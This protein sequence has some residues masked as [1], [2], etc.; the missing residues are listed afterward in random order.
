MLILAASGILLRLMERADPQHGTIRAAVRVLIAR[1]DELV[2][3]TQE[4]YRNALQRPPC[5]VRWIRRISLLHLWR[6]GWD[7]QAMPGFG[8]PTCSE[9]A[10]LE[11]NSAGEPGLVRRRNGSP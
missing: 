2:T 9:I 7:I 1:G 11:L 6:T 10:C 3:A 8:R 4:P 5:A